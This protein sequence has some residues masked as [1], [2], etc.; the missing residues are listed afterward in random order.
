MAKFVIADIIGT[1][2]IP[3][4]LERIVPDLPSVPVQPLILDSE[5]EYALFENVRRHPWVLEPYRYKN[6][7][8][9]LSTFDK[10]VITPAEEKA[11]EIRGKRR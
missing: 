2:S 9:L 5:Y 1:K 4:E 7:G 10:N 8:E 6:Q 3:A 11:E